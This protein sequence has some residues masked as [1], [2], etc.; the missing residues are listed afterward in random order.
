MEDRR[1]RK[2][3]G[4]RIIK[5]APSKVPRVIGKKGTM[6][7]QI[8]NKT[9]TKIIVGQNGLV[10]IKGENPNLAARAVK[11]VEE[12]AHLS[13]LTDKIDEWLE[14]EGGSNE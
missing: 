8:K 7:R 2:L 12:E 9:E 14:E 6:V 1:C 4:G 11:K 5:I 13:G 3:R 10:W